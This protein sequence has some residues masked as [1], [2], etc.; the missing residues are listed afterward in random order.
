MIA[1]PNIKINLGLSVMRKRE[2][3]YHDLE[4]LF[5][6]CNAFRDSLSISEN[7][8]KETVINIIGGD[9]D[10]RT[11]LCYR[12]WELLNAKFDIPGV[13]IILEKN[14][15]VGA[16]LGGGSADAAYTL[17]ML[18]EIFSLGLTV[19]YLV[20]FASELGSDC[21]F[22]IF[23]KPMIAE[24][25]GDVLERYDISLK[26]YNL[27]LEV[28]EGVH[29]STKEA[30]AHVGTREALAAEGRVLMPLREALAC[31]VEQ[32]KDVLLND[33][34]PSVFSSHPE[35]ASLKQKMYDEGAVYASMSGSGSAVFGLFRK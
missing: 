17:M 11:D 15:P 24:G 25:R 9:W 20:Y 18:N 34:E 5:L 3:G 32:W 13:D 1:Y 10:P 29:V 2:D 33:F 30:Y 12:A 7:G 23:N 4:T 8:M 22:F 35:I 6:P 26:D 28:P 19:P 16:G 27:R 21:P 14:S 31:P